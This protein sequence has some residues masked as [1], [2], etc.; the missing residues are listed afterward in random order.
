[1]KHLFS[2]GGE[3]VSGSKKEEVYLGCAWLTTDMNTFLP[4]RLKMHHHVD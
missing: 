3:R 1:M 2:L 4:S